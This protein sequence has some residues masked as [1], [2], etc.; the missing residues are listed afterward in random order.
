M[1]H[2]TNNNHN[3]ATSRS[4][5]SKGLRRRLKNNSSSSSNRGVRTTNSNQPKSMAL[6]QSRYSAESTVNSSSSSSS[7]SQQ[8]LQQ[9]QHSRYHNDS[10]NNSRYNNVDDNN[11]RYKRFPNKRVHPEDERETGHQQQHSN[12]NFIRN[13]P[14]GPKRRQPLPV[15]K[16]QQLPHSLP[17]GPAASSRYDPNSK[18]KQMGT[19]RTRL[20]PRP[21][22]TK[23]LGPSAVS[24]NSI[25]VPSTTSRDHKKKLYR[26]HRHQ[27][28]FL[29]QTRTSSI[30]EQI[31]QVGEGTY[32]KVFK[33]KNKNTKQLVALKKL[34]LNSE[35]DGFPITSIREIKLLQSFNHENIAV[36]REIMVES[37]SSSS[38]NSS[39]SMS[40]SSSSNSGQSNL[41]NGSSNIGI[42]NSIYMIFQYAD[43]DLT[44]LLNDKN[45]QIKPSQCK[46][47]LK[48]L[49]HGVQYLH[50]SF[51]LHRDIKGSN[52][53][54]DNLGN[55]K[56]TDFGLARK[57]LPHSPSDKKDIINDYTNRVIT[58]WYRPP[59]LLMG[60]TN[61]STE[62]DMWGCGCILIELFNKVAIFQ[63]MN[64]IEQLVSIFK[65]LGSPTLENFPN[66]FSMP[67]FFMIIPLLNEKYNDCFEEKFK[68]ILPS[69]ECLKLVRGLLLY[70][71]SKRLS[72]H[73]ALQ[74]QYFIEDPKPEPLILKGYGGSHEYEMKLARRLQKREEMKK[75]SKS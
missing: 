11:N 47:L 35:K 38:A 17:S 71:Q 24:P 14:R 67:W 37:I 70:D 52:I 60:T 54:V 6:Q 30:Y 45:L 5:N 22:F 23:T 18:P 16:Q 2:P 42:I 41:L 31:S 19:A 36:L 61:Y 66:F 65:I 55:L 28:L 9:R 74:S 12:P 48:Q 64:E 75:H 7:S 3:T 63:G 4:N 26:L 21:S 59:E 29:T 50:D 1:G 34:R 69:E 20:P 49:L 27:L 39:P 57:I 25:P 51:I 15:S 13:L 68:N 58:L 8:Q 73:E 72:A 62:V 56:I 44:G 32:G 53:L 40:S 10:T 46:H 43:N 33:S